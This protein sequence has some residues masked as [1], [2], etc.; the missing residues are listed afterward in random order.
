MVVDIYKFFTK[1]TNKQS[2]HNVKEKLDD[3]YSMVI[4][5]AEENT[6]VILEKWKTVIA[7]IS[8]ITPII[9]YT[10]T[11][12]IEQEQEATILLNKI[13]TPVNN[14]FTLIDRLLTSYMIK[15]VMEDRND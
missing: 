8:N 11:S 5:Y 13:Y 1:F 9:I 6:K 15:K 4:I 14:Q 7:K 3:E 2:I 12:R 10:G